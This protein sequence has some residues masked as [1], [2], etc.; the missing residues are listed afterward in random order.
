[1]KHQVTIIGILTLVINLVLGAAAVTAQ[2]SNP[3][4]V[5]VECINVPLNSE[6]KVTVHPPAC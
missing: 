2:T 4:L 1:M 6:V 5:V 3:V